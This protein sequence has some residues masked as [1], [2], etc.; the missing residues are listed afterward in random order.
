MDT[1]DIRD[2]SSKLKEACDD[3]MAVRSVLLTV[4]DHPE[5]ANAAQAL[6]VV[7][8]ALG[9]VIDDIQEAVDTIERSL[10]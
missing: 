2:S 6:K 5:Y 4:S 3:L 10:I 9:P 1:T 7:D 8:R